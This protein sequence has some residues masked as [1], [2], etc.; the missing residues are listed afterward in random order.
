MQTI[1]EHLIATIKLAY[2]VSIGQL[3][4]IMMG[5]VDSVMVGGLGAKYLAAAS[6]SN[7]IFILILIIGIGVSYAVSPLV[8]I[9]VGAKKYSDCE[10]M[11]K[12]SLL[13]N[14]MLGLVLL[15]ITFFFS[16][17]IKYL[18]EP[19][20]VTPLAISYTKILGY[21]IL[22]VMLFQTYKQFIEGLSFTRPAMFITIIAN[23]INL[24]MNWIL[25]YGKF[26]FPAL[27]LNGSGW[28]TFSSRL[29]MG[30]I[31]MIYVMNSKHFRGYNLSPKFSR[32]NLHV[33]KKILGLGLPSAFQYA[34]EVGAFTYAIIM[35]GW[36]G[37]KQLAAHQIAINLATIS[38]MI[39]LG[40]S[41]AGAIRVGNAL[42][43]QNIIEVRRAGF[44]AIILGASLMACFGIIFI[45]FKNL[46]PS[47]YI[48]DPE[49]I[50]IAANL[51]IVAA[52]FQIFDGTQAVGIG[53]LRGLTDVKGPT[54]ITF[55][56]YWIIALPIGYFL[57]F[58]LHLKVLGVWIGLSFGLVVAAVLLS[59][60][61]NKKSKQ[62]IKI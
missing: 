38:Y 56:A 1:K 52:I 62:L 23:L 4:F 34:F 24:L 3:G 47:L 5:V 54:I 19:A 49:V 57:G 58:N 60:R 8:A 20:G 33:I 22:P 41:S 6:L 43:K 17:F 50:S 27:G 31:L 18:D 39:T 61:F 42:G 13:I 11:F 30:I 37:T 44:T 55:F 51:L 45:S 53:V 48:N 16:V 9:A 36:L 32:I 25:I 46:L 2:P 12:Q 10:S 21:S 59:L 14:F 26:G 15:A 35:V 40:I 29:F 7:G 28:A